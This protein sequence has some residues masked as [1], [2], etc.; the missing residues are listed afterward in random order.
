[1]K[2]STGEV[3]QY[4]W[5]G[6]FVSEDKNR[7]YYDSVK[8]SDRLNSYN[9]EIFSVGEIVYFQSDT[10][11]PYIAEIESLYENKSTGTKHVNAKWYYRTQDVKA[12]AP[13]A[14]DNVNYKRYSEL[15][16]SDMKDEND[17]QSILK[18]VNVLFFESDQEE[19]INSIFSASNAI[20]LKDSF[21][22]R[23]RFDTNA[24][25]LVKLKASE[26]SMLQ[27]K[28]KQNENQFIQPGK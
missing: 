22:C 7:A 4:R 15:F 17:V 5:I 20:K 12:L 26:V 19:T 1:M 2:K 25:K 14:L 11:L 13:Q 8:I 27:E 18:H 28:Y 10:S 3:R 9:S 24:L 16:L 21:F 6:S 23:H